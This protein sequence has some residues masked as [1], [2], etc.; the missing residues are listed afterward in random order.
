MGY[1][2]DLLIAY[3]VALITIAA[4]IFSTWT[5]GRR[6]SPER[7]DRSPKLVVSDGGRWHRPAA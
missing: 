3:A 4:T 2:T 6:R 7:A 5:A 1:W